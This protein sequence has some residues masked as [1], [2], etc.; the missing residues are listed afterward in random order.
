MIEEIKIL[1]LEKLKDKLEK[2]ED[3]SIQDLS[4]ASI[5]INNIDDS[6]KIMFEALVSK[7]NELKTSEVKNDE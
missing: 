1:I 5:M 2:T 6:Q 4:S 7:M 3:L